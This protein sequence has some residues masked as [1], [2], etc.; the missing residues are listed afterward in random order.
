MLYHVF[1]RRDVI[2]DKTVASIKAGLSGGD[3]PVEVK[4]FDNSGHLPHLD[5]REEYVTVREQAEHGGRVT[6]ITL[7]TSG[8]SVLVRRN[9]GL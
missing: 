8:S 7:F 3:A 1:G 9:S 4:Q 5:E 2:G 6:Y